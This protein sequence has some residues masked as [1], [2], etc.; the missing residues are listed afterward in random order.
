MKKLPFFLM[1]LGI[2]IIVFVILI[3][4]NMCN[5]VQNMNGFYGFN[6]ANVIVKNKTENS[7]FT[8]SDIDKFG[9]ELKTNE[10]GYSTSIQS[11]VLFEH[12]SFDTKI[13]GVNLYYENFID[14]NIICGG[15]FTAADNEECNR[16]AVIDSNLAWIIFNNDDVIGQKIELLDTTFEIVGV[17]EKYS[18]LEDE[19]NEN[20]IEKLTSDGLSNVYIPVDT[21]VD[22]VPDTVIDTIYVPTKSNN[23]LGENEDKINTAL[24][25]IQKLPSNYEITDFNINKTL[26]YQKPKIIIFIIALFIL[27]ILIFVIK[28]ELKK[29]FRIIKEYMKDYYISEVIKKS[30]CRVKE[31]T[32]KVFLCVIVGVVILIN[33]KFDL[34]VSPE[35]IPDELIDTKYYSDLFESKI[36]EFN[37]NINLVRTTNQLEY[38]IADLLTNFLLAIGILIGIPLFYLGVYQLQNNS[39]NIIRLLLYCAGFLVTCLLLVLP[40]LNKLG[41]PH[42]FDVKSIV[43]MWIYIFASTLYSYNKKSKTELEA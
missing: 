17:Y 28:N 2:L 23:I 43:I 16:V 12:K 13:S 6:K 38:N 40:V 35:Y 41:L 14:L 39:I 26:I 22:K 8:L 42:I 20:I 29:I 32:A 9:E 18:L 15:F 1:F 27:S 31:P 33:I 37:Q 30:W 11:S 10:L 21:L 25:T 19:R 5:E 4:N 34:Y 3:S 36:H 24:Q 7:M